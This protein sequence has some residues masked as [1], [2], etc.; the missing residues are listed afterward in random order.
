MS[1]LCRCEDTANPCSHLTG[2]SSQQL[3]WRD[4][5]IPKIPTHPCG[6]GIPMSKPP[7]ALV[8]QQHTTS[9]LHEEGSSKGQEGDNISKCYLQS[10]QIPGVF[11]SLWQSC[12]FMPYDLAPS[13]KDTAQQCSFD[14]TARDASSSV[15]GLGLQIAH[16]HPGNGVASSLLQV[17]S[18]TNGCVAAPE[19]TACLG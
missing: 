11:L 4:V 19:N 3:W 5:G 13:S 6:C 9:L 1:H 17:G 18:Y 15:P 14:S 7:K 16:L 2:H 10:T 8:T 12:N